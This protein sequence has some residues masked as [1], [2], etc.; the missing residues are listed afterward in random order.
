M[1]I[2]HWSCC[3]QDLEERCGMEQNPEFMG[4][5]EKPAGDILQAFLIRRHK[6]TRLGAITLEPV[7]SSVSH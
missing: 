1:Q 3:N 4:G 6:E 5:Q 7:A 2:L